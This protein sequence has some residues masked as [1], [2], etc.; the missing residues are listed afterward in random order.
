MNSV[1]QSSLSYTIWVIDIGAALTV[2]TLCNK[3]ILLFD[4][5]KYEKYGTLPIYTHAMV[6]IYSIVCKGL[7]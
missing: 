2:K 3:L 6:E 1:S 5:A 4:L 7:K